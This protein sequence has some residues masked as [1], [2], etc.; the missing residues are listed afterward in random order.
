M[1]RIVDPTRLGQALGQ[2]RE[3]AGI[4][5]RACARTLAEITGRTETSV[6]SQLWTW[7]TGGNQPDLKSLGPYLKA[8]GVALALDFVES[9]CDEK[10]ATAVHMARRELDQD[11]PWIPGGVFKTDERLKPLLLAFLDSLVPPVS[12]TPRKDHHEVTDQPAA[13]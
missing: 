13:G 5:R 8:I 7:D 3:L 10:M 11:H 9:P 6:N 1:I 4:S 12:A 2:V